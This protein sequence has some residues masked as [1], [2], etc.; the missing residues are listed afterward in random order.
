MLCMKEKED[1]L[2]VEAGGTVSK[3]PLKQGVITENIEGV[4]L[5]CRRRWEEREWKR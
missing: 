3:P 1:G 5:D 2:P 4:S